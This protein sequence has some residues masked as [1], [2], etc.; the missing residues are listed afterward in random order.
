ME[1][2][3]R[4]IV[5]NNAQTP[6]GLI[7]RS[8]AIDWLNSQ[9]TDSVDFTF[10]SPPYGKARKYGEL[11]FKLTGEDWIV[12]MRG[13]LQECVRV[14]NGM[15]C[16][17][18]NGNTKDFKY[19]CLPECLIAD[20]HRSGLNLRK[21]HV[22]YRNGISGSGGPDWFRDDWEYVI[23]LS[24]GRRLEWTDILSIGNP[25]KYP[26]GGAMSHRK[27]NDERVEK[28]EYIPPEIANP[29]NVHKISV[30]K[31]HMGD[32]LAHENEAPFPES[33]AE[34][35]IKTLCPPNGI[36]LDIMSG[37]GT[38]AAV[39]QK[40][41]RRY[42]AVDVRQSQVELMRKRLNYAGEGSYVSN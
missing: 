41:G 7:L 31:G 20:L 34:R 38:T 12:W 17:V 30:G 6:R 1:L 18:V 10:F 37:S 16:C 29:G 11:D 15:V 21:P 42:I 14:T 35:F 13:I 2:R 8:D 9:D 19:N 33:L 27:S 28:K 25:P 39:A 3:L 22:F 5:T 23:C 4:S 32:D 40:L 26:P 36:V 24:K